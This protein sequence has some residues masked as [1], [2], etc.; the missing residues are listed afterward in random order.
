V[1]NE[2]GPKDKRPNEVGPK[3]KRPNEVGPKDK[4]NHPMKSC[5]GGCSVLPLGLVFL[6]HLLPLLS[7]DLAKVLLLRFS[8]RLSIAKI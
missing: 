6:V 1:A 2:V 8:W 4:K 3:D 5:C 7:L